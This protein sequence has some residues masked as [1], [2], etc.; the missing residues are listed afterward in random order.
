MTDKEIR[1]NWRQEWLGC[2]AEFSDFDTQ[3]RMWLDVENTNPHWSFVEYMCSY[4]DDLGLQ[5][6]DYQGRID[7][8]FVT[9]EEVAAINE[10]HQI[11][12]GYQSPTDD[13]DHR[14]ILDDP[15]W[16][17][18]VKAAQKAKQQLLA[19]ISDNKE[20]QDLSGVNA[21]RIEARWKY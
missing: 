16:H 13:Y 11:A 9:E 1:R 15:K 14:A 12:D 18:V 10:F 8:G 2:V 7:A 19:L 21:P 17:E 3:K 5:V 4:F 20:R 6:V